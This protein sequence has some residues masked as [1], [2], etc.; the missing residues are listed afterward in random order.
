VN[1]K[2]I[3]K[4][5]NRNFAFLATMKESTK[6]NFLSPLAISLISVFVLTPIANA[7]YDPKQKSIAIITPVLRFFSYMWQYIFN[8]KVSVWIILLILVFIIFI[9]KSVEKLKLKEIESQVLNTKKPSF[10]RYT[11]GVLK[12]WKWSWKYDIDPIRN[13]FEI[14]DLKPYCT[15]CDIK[16]LVDAFGD[17]YT[18]PNCN[19]FKSVLQTP[20]EHPIKIAALIGNK[21]EKNEY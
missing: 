18:C 9:L 13:T 4:I 1:F 7:L 5:I 12:E 21:I 20:S 8:Y 6:N 17:T 19:H 16:M 15:K 14:V 3:Q 10:L 11:E 2:N